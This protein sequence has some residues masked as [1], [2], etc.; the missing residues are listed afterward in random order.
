MLYI[1]HV[2]TVLGAAYT[3]YIRVSFWGTQCSMIVHVKHID[4]LCG[5]EHVLPCSMPF[6]DTGRGMGCMCLQFSIW[7]LIIV[8]YL[9]H[10]QSPYGYPLV[11][12]HGLELTVTSPQA[13]IL[14][15]T[16]LVSVCICT[17]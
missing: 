15:I 4:L 9:H 16:V 5:I 7:E 6:T 11:I 14:A 2:C 1:L 8:Y 12:V 17:Q 13:I 3:L 10:L